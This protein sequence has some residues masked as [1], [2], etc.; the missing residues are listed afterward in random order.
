MTFRVASLAFVACTIL[1]S[2]P[3]ATQLPGVVPRE[4]EPPTQQRMRDQ[5]VPMR[6]RGCIR[7]KRLLLTEPSFNDNVA[8]ILNADELL[9]EGSKDL[10]QQLHRE[11]E[12]HDDD[13]IGVAIIPPTP[14]GT[15]TTDVKSKELGK[16]GRVTMGVSERSGPTAN[17]R[18]PVRFKVTGVHH[19]HEGCTRY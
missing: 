17:V 13:L 8:D 10:M 4:K 6:V 18:L 9:L 19:L 3:A 16:K 5:Q 15:S 14:D 7:G 2:A 12:G 1:P 11:H